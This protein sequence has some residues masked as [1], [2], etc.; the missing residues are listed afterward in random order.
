M[1]SIR[2]LLKLDEEQ[3][4]NLINAS[5]KEYPILKSIYSDQFVKELVRMQFNPN[6]YLLWLLA[7]RSEFASKQLEEM[8]NALES[9]K[10][11]NV[12]TKF[13]GKLTHTNRMIF[14]SYLSELEFA[15]YYKQK[16]YQIEV[17][18]YI[19]GTLKGPD[20]KVKAENTEIFFEIENIFIQELMNIDRVD[21][22]ISTRLAVVEDPFV[23][24]IY[25]FDM[26]MTQR[27]VETLV[28]FVKRSLR[29]LRDK[30]DVRF[31]IILQFPDEKQRKAE[32]H[33]VGRPNKLKHGYLGGISWIHSG[34][35]S[36]SN[37]RRKI[38]KKISQLPNKAA[39]VLVIQLGHLFYDEED[40]LDALFG[41]LKLRINLKDN[42]SKPIRGK[43]RIFTPTKNTRLSAVIYY[44]KKFQNHNFN[45]RKVVFH[46]P[47][48]KIP[49]GA[50]FFQDY[51]VKQFVP[52]DKGA[53]YE[54][55]SIE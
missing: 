55:E 29:E 30:N 52:K 46:N 13:Q 36:S 34:F 5:L 31:P 24:F 4:L 49:I 32:I 8:A 45:Y 48:A 43:E 33:I 3:L 42:S 6:N 11:I 50:K 40:I 26:E 17:E 7:S 51:N 37:I 44:E 2:D 21:S 54:M 23:Y 1:V 14:E 15:S 25:R 47:Y 28:V 10:E 16:G 9:L 19:E 39:N 22:E 18:P 12:I 27:D 38:S 41:D 20:L 35:P 53:Y